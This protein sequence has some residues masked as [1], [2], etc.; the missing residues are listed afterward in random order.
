M[1][2][3]AVL[4]IL[5]LNLGNILQTILAR[6]QSIDKPIMLFVHGGPGYS[7]FRFFRSIIKNLK[8]TLLPLT[9]MKEELAYLITILYLFQT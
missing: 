1:G 6:G 4:T 3:I 7:E 5:K 2:N 9:G 8:T